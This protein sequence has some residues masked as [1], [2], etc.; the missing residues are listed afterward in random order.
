VATGTGTAGGQ[1]R[2]VPGPKLQKLKRGLIDHE[3]GGTYWRP[4]FDGPGQP[5]RDPVTRRTKTPRGALPISRMSLLSPILTRAQIA[6]R[7]MRTTLGPTSK[8]SFRRSTSA[9]LTT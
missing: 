8:A 2:E 9:S 1:L 3:V 6:R 5:R 4:T 7:L